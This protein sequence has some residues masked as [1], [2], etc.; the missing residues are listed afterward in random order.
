MNTQ[1]NDEI[2]IK[3]IFWIISRYKWMII[4]FTIIFGLGSGYYAYFKP[5]IYKATATVEVGLSQR[6][7]S[8]DILSM[9]TDP[10][11]LNPD[12]E[13]AIITSRFLA[14]KASKEVDRT[15]HYYTKIK[16]KQVELYKNSPF[17]V[18]MNSGFGIKFYFYPI[19]E[20]HYRLVAKDKDWSFDK[21]LEYDKEIKNK[22]FHINITKVSKPEASKYT[23]IIDNPNII[24]PGNV[25][26]QQTSK[27]SRILAISYEDNVPLRAKEYVNALAKAYIQ[28]NIEKKTKE[29]SKK[30]EFIDNQL[31]YITQN[32]RASAIKIEDFKKKAKTINLSSK[33]E[34]IIKTISQKDAKLSE[35]SMKEEILN[36]LYNS[37]KKG[38]NLESLAI[39]GLGEGEASLSDMVTKLQ[40]AILKKKLLREDYTEMY[41]EVRKLTK[42]IYQLKKIIIST[43]KNMQKS[44][45]EQKALLQR[46]IDKQQLLLDKL[47]A[48]ERMFGQLKRKFAVNEKIY[49]YLLEKRSETA[50]IKASTVSKNRII[51]EALSPKKPIKPK[52]KL[53]VFIGLIMGFIFGILVAFIRNYL[54]D[55]I[56]NEDD[57]SH[58]TN[59]PVVGLIPHMKENAD[60]LS[61]LSSPKS[62]VAESFRNLRTNLQFMVSYRGAQVIAITST[63]S[64]EGK[65]TLAVN[66]SAVM[67]IAD[68]KTI[69]LN[70]DMRKPTLHEKFD[71]PNKKGM[72]SL[73]SGNAT[74]TEVIQK[75]KYKNIDVITS[76][77]I[78]PNP[79]ELIQSPLMEKLIYKLKEHYDV[80]ILDTPPIGLVTDARTLMHLADTSLYVI[81]VEYSKK[82]FLKTVN[83]LAS[84]EEIRSLGIILNDIPLGKKGYG[85]GYSYGYGYGYYE[86]DTK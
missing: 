23:F 69:I 12:T 52:R 46:E 18:G 48:D 2:D 62:S 39:V 73:L 36:N 76:G 20:K 51:D 85:Y 13:K 38:K 32:L 41:P 66:L 77:P 29:A 33:A 58:L 44:I 9:A 59:V 19:D 27:Y 55:T 42:T 79:S 34:S 5:N 78:P 7:S 28:Q 1:Q 14:K 81:R 61:I 47:P 53:I 3:E 50:I 24:N 75:T 4:F 68:K 16:L 26:V 45:Q 40:D 82:E 22:H 70:L 57:I 35:V 80:V 49:S 30:L 21:K 86:D 56:K 74:L 60:K 64:G 11:R 25:D 67:S 71:I 83:F 15:H 31:K 43:I 84:L 6:I 8:G 63:I 72:S 54:D 65:T 37:V 17:R 10:G